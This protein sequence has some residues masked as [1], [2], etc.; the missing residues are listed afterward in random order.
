[1]GE[2]VIVSLLLMAYVLWIVGVAVFGAARVRERGGLVGCAGVILL[3]FGVGAVFAMAILLATWLWEWTGTFLDG[4]ELI[5]AGLTLFAWLIVAWV[6][7][8]S[9]VIVDKVF[10][11]ILGSLA[12]AVVGGSAVWALFG[13]LWQTVLVGCAMGFS[14][15]IEGADLGFED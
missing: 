6:L 1:M 3:L 12:A 7:S 13:V 15:F 9:V 2:E 11:T 5:Q 14:M 10:G 4:P 8:W